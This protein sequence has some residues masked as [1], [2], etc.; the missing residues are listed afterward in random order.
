VDYLHH[1]ISSCGEYF[2]EVEAF[3]ALEINR[4]LNSGGALLD[5]SG[6]VVKKTPALEIVDED[7][8]RDGDR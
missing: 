3:H 4:R 1:K 7:R 8:G 6:S 2:H 5:M